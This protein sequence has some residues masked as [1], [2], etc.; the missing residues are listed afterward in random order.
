[1]HARM[2]ARLMQT[3]RLKPPSRLPNAIRAQNCEVMPLVF[4]YLKLYATSLVYLQLPAFYVL[5]SCYNNAIASWW[6]L[7]HLSCIDRVPDCAESHEADDNDRS[8]VHRGGS[9]WQSRRHA[10]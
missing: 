5:W 9:H 7:V 4:I 1:M 6:T 10:E 8:V 3:D 2:W